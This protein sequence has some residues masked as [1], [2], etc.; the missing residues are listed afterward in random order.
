MKAQYFS[1]LWTVDACGQ[2]GATCSSARAALLTILFAGW[3][4][5][6]SGVSH[7]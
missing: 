5:P 3:S 2:G 1:V 7:S 4:A 6:A